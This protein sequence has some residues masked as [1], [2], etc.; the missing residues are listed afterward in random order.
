MESTITFCR[1]T[2]H[3]VLF[4]QWGLHRLEAMPPAIANALAG[5][6]LSMCREMIANISSP[7]VFTT[8]AFTISKALS[9]KSLDDR[10]YAQRQYDE[11]WAARTAYTCISLFCTLVLALML[12]KPLFTSSPL[13]PAD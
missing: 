5:P 11:E 1:S 8:T 7:S 10:E 6:S 12:G 2:S 13:P 4:V 3:L 9:R